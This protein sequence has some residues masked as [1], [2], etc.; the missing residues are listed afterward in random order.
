[1]CLSFLFSFTVVSSTIFGAPSLGLASQFFW[2]LTLSE[3]QLM[4]SS[5]PWQPDVQFP[6]L[7]HMVISLLMAKIHHDMLVCMLP[8]D[9][10]PGYRIPHA[11][12]S[13]HQ[14]TY[15]CRI[16]LSRMHLRGKAV[17]NRISPRSSC[18]SP[19]R[20]MNNEAY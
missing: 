15:V 19:V 17:G 2:F 8:N 16:R 7:L 20:N 18:L 3:W 12:E 13:K 9:L 4:I 14:A 11:L 10:K 6:A 5:F 1:M